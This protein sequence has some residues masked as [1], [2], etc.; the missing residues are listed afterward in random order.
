MY[1]ACE[2]LRHIRIRL[3][4][5]F[6]GWVHATRLGDAISLVAGIN[7][8]ISQGSIV[9]PPSYVVVASDLHPKHRRNAMTNYADDTYLMIG[10]SNIHTTAEE[11]GNI[12]A[13]AMRSN[14]QINVNCVTF[15][16]GDQTGHQ[17]TKRSDTRGK[18]GVHYDNFKVKK[19]ISY[20]CDNLE[21]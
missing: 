7:A 20:S 16:D 5:Y 12:Q 18:W 8:S 4:D 21:A 9:G 6:E 14:L 11:F 10:S 15:Q 13:W 3:V 1:A 19:S 2:A 17:Y